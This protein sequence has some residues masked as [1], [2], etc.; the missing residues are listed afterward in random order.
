MGVIKK[1][2]ITEK[3]QKLSENLNQYS[4]LVDTAAT[5]DEIIAEVHKIYGVEV[6]GIST[7][8]YNGKR[9]ARMSKSGMV[10]G[11]KNAFKKAIVTINEDQV[12]DFF[13]SI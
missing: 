5:K 9:K 7:M 8:R 2:L 11:R 4:F 6:K 12:I 1:P 3:S 13:E 10:I